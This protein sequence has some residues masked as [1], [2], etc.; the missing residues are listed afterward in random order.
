MQQQ[1][2][3]VM[4]DQKVDRDIAGRGGNALPVTGAHI[5]IRNYSNVSSAE[6]SEHPLQSSTETNSL[7]VTLQNTLTQDF[8]ET[9]YDAI[10]CATGYERNSWLQL[11]KTSSL[12]RHFGL[13][14]TSSD[15]TRLSVDRDFGV[16]EE[17]N[18]IFKVAANGRNGHSQ[19]TD[20]RNN[21]DG[22]HA[23]YTSMETKVPGTPPTSRVIKDIGSHQHDRYTLYL[24]TL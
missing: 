6:I 15:K 7:S 2:Y 17:K 22:I 21:A 4:Y 12:G 3:E 13:R 8:S 10:I 11:L 23:P 1:L 14:A 16:A 19:T 9:T 20:M 18:G 24:A 5:T